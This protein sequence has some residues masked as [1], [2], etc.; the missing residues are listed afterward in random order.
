MERVNLPEIAKEVFGQLGFKDGARFVTFD[1]DPKIQEMA[2]QL[3]ELQGVIQSE[4]MKLQ[5]RVQIEQ[6]KQQGNLQSANIKSVT[7]LKIAQL[8]MQMDYI[9][10]QL[11]GEDVATRRAELELQKKR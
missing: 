2:A 4:Q 1:E 7:E 5:N 11:K 9:D 10:L 3:E 6:M 8:K